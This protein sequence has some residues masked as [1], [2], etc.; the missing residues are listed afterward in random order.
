MSFIFDLPKNKKK[1]KIR[2]PESANI[3]A[4]DILVHRVNHLDKVTNNLD[5]NIDNIIDHVNN[6][7]D[8]TE[9]NHKDL[10]NKFINANSINEMQHAMLED[11]IGKMKDQIKTIQDTNE[12]KHALLEDKIGK[13]KDQIKNL[14]DTN[15]SLEKNIED[16]AEQLEMLN[17]RFKIAG[18]ILAAVFALVFG[19]IFVAMF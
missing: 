16:F 8:N 11:K 19:V 6:F 7:I 10:M 5:K 14:Q 1:D 12:M 3:N 2:S 4:M 18:C 15:D 17:Y 9:N 13:M